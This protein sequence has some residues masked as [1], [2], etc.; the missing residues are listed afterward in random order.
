[1]AMIIW[2]SVGRE[3]SI[4]T[5]T[6]HCPQ[7]NGQQ[8]YDHR[9]VA[10]Y[11]TLYFIPL[12][13]TETLGEFISCQGCKTPFKPEILHYEPPTELQQMVDATDADLQSGTPVQMARRKLLNAGAAEATA[14]E[15]IT[16]CTPDGQ[17]NCRKCDLSFAMKV[18]RCSNCGG[19]L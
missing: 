9:R 17:R 3:T 19:S 18:R 8:L 13:P 14:N 6:F 16:A 11:F 12:F 1:M 5:G 2:G 15:I 4:G 7:C 10:R